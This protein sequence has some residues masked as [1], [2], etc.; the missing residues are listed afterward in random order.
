MIRS[1]DYLERIVPAVMRRLEE[2]RALVPLAELQAVGGG[3]TRASFSG[4]V[5]EPGVS[6]IAEVKRASPSKGLI[7][8]DLEVGELVTAYETA[9][10]RAVS[11]LTEQDF[12]LGSLDDL[13]TAAEHTAPASAAQG[14]HRRRVSALRGPVGRSVRGPPYRGSAR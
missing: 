10:A 4:A 2:R 6:L 3:A 7:R 9:G 8:P 5:G 1:G 11:V 14:L 13:R 12:F